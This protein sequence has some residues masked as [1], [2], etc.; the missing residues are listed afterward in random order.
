MNYDLNT[1]EGMRNAQQWMN[2]IIFGATHDT[3]VWLVPRSGTLVS[4]NKVTKTARVNGLVPDPSIV[5]VL[6]SMGWDVTEGE[7][8]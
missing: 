3:G 7:M 5:R 1:A 4:F 6:K 2:T 8:K